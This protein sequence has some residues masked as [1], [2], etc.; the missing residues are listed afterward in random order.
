MS[1]WLKMSQQVSKQ[2]SERTEQQNA[3]VKSYQAA[4]KEE[5]ENF[6]CL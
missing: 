2:S 1:E 6:Y 3:A 4:C 5:K